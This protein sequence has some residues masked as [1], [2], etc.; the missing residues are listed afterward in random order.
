MIIS[1]TGLGDTLWATPAIRALR[2][3][4]PDAYVSILTSPVGNSLLQNNPHLDEIFVLKK[5]HFFYATFLFLKL[6]RRKVGQILLFHASQRLVYALCA[7]L[8][9][10]ALIATRG[11]NKGLDEIF[12]CLLEQQPVHEVE[13]RLQIVRSVGGKV[14]CCGLELF[15]TQSHEEEAEAF[16]KKQK[17]VPHLPLVGLHPGAKDHFKQWPEEH[18]IAVGSLLAHHLG[19]QIL[20]TGS[21]DERALVERIASKIEGAI[22]VCDMLSLGGVS[23]L[24]RKFSLIICNDTGPMHI[25]FA[26]HTPTLALFVPTDPRLCGPYFA[27]K[28]HVISK[29]RTCTPCLRKKCADAFCLLQISPEEV[30]D[31][32]LN[33]FYQK[34]DG[35]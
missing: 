9:P 2:E 12:T 10:W 11:S 22:G 13:R 5:P 18:F 21:G 28:Y 33:L 3:S 8:R 35:S 24:I 32:A 30:Y 26:V 1:T 15:L 16:L 4:F 7:L 29:K 27:G 14:S 25:A 20:V 34:A 17:I 31:A 23:A 19:A 6:R